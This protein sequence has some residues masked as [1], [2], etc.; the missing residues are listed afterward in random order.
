MKPRFLLAL[1]LG[2]SSL[3]ITAH[4]EGGCPPG[5]MPYSST[6]ISSC[7]LIPGYNNPQQQ[8]APQPTPPRWA[9]RWGAVVADIPRGVVGASANMFNR[10][11]AEQSAMADCSA[12]DGKNCKLETWYSN[13]CVVLVVGD[14]G[15]NVTAEATL[16][17]ATALGTKFCTDAKRTNCHVY[18]SACSP[19]VRIQ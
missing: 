18:Y 15:Y 1:L 11:A 19:P 13:G 6:N 3:R 4:A 16:D 9:D 2:L 7:G 8:A 14:G 12:Q 17:R 5:W 10:Q